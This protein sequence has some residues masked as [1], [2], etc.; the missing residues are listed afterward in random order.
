MWDR[1]FV[2]ESY[3]SHGIL[4]PFVSMFLILFKKDELKGIKVMP[5]K[6]GLALIGTALLMHLSSSFVK[7]Y[8]TS[9]LSLIVLIMGLVL[10]F[11]GTVY[12]LK[13]LY[14]ILF[15]LFMVPMPMVFVADVSVKLKLFAAQS[16]T[17]ILN[18]IGIY[19]A[20][21]GSTIKTLRSYLMVE[22]PCSG[23]RSL[24]SLFSLGVLVV[25]FMKGGW[26]RKSILVLLTIPIAIAA[27]IF[28]IVLL[29][30]VSEIYG[31]K[32]AMGWFHSFSGF[33]LFFVALIGFMLV[34]E[35]L[36]D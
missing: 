15:L 34:K 1:W 28:R 13:F 17:F 25:Y 24:I 12:F 10:Y 31:E 19:A 2:E 3:Y 33:L 23:I 14:P 22:G 18:H 5:N 35:V 36:N 26:I 20:R 21:D 27:N 16:A 11:L 6:V 7:V 29:A 4:I 30:S 8:F 32:F 9:G